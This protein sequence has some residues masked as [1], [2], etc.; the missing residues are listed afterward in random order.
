MACIKL[1]LGLIPEIEG[2]IMKFWWVKEVIV[3]RFIMLT[4]L[5]CVNQKL[6]VEW[7]SRNK[8]Y[9][10]MIFLQNRLGG[11]YIIKT[12]YSIKFSKQSFSKIA[13]L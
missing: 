6:L 2:L 7:V 11:S 12:L 4:G 3:E 1:P 8:L 9:S 5:V 13:Q 10:M